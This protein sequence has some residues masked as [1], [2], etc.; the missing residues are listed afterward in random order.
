MYKPALYLTCI[1]FTVVALA[2]S[3][4]ATKKYVAAQLAPVNSKV[5]ALETKTNDQADREATDV[6]RLE[7]KLGSTDAKVAEVASVA[8][9]ANATADQADRLAEQDQSAIKSDETAI[10]ANAA[11]ITALDKAMNYSLVA[12]AD[13]TFGFNKS[14]LGKTDEAALDALVQ[15]AQSTPRVAFEL[16]GF[17]DPVG[18]TEYN[19][20]L[21]R[22]RADSVARYLVRQG[23]PLRGIHIIGLGKEPVPAGFLADVQAVDPN[24]TRAD[25]MRLARRVRIRLYAPNASTQIS[26]LQ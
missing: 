12:K 8:Q 3:G 6:S 2:T 16:V 24:I 9:K 5:S 26:S 23:I 10:A 19:L 7:E 11:S 22:R 17:T 15:Q 25:A 1:G 14:K 21:S 13:V 18:S 20:G 4:C